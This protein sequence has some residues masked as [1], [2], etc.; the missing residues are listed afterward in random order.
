MPD[1]APVDVAPVIAAGP[2]TDVAPPVVAVVPVT[3]AVVLV[4]FTLVFTPRN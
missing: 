4:L 3:P 1:V 2:L